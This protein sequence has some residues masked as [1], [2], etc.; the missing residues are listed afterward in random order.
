M[1]G[2]TFDGKHTSTISGLDVVVEY[3]VAMLPDF[4]NKL[5]SLEKLDGVLDFG[6]SIKER[7]IPVRFM[8]KGGS[9]SDYFDKAFAVA[10]WL[11]VD[12]A[13]ELQLDAIPNKR[14]FARLNKGIDPTRFAS[15]GEV[16]VEF[17]CPDPAFESLVEKNFVAVQ[18]TNYTNSGTK[19]VKPYFS[20]KFT[21]AQASPFRLNLNGTNKFILVNTAF[22]LNDILVI[23][24][25]TRKFTKNGADI[26]P[27]IDV[28]SAV[29][30]FQFPTGTFQLSANTANVQITTIFRE[31]WA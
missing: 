31:R 15:V 4:E 28:T 8:L 20:I 3:N 2:F 6:R 21:A 7:V 30:E 25:R 26:R 27:N 19:S 17:L 29:T 10:A 18:N 16:E 1:N 11:N 14:I 5:V 13:K 22:A 24:I 12:T 9:I 23:D